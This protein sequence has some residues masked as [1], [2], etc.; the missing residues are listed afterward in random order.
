MKAAI[1]NET[2]DTTLKDTYKVK[3]ATWNESEDIMDAED[4]AV[5]DY[6]RKTHNITP[7]TIPYQSI[8]GKYKMPFNYLWTM[9]VYSQDKDYVFD[10][11]KLVDNSKIEITIHDNYTETTNIVI[12]EYTKYRKIYTTANA[13]VEYYYFDYQAVPPNVP[14][15]PP[16]RSGSL[17]EKVSAATRYEPHYTNTHTTINRNNTLDIALTLADSWFAKYTKEYT[18]NKPT[19]TTSPPSTSSLDDILNEPENV[20]G[21]F[22]GHKDNLI[23]KAESKVRDDAHNIKIYFEDVNTEYTSK[24]LKRSTTTKNIVESSSY[25]S[26]V[27][28]GGGI[29]LGTSIS[30]VKTG[31]LNKDNYIELPSPKTDGDGDNPLQGFC[32]VEDSM[33]AYVIHHYSTGTCSLFLVDSNTTEEYDRTGGF[34]GHGNTIAYDPVNAEII[35]PEDGVIQLVKVNKA[36]KKFEGRRS[37]SPPQRVNSPSQIAYNATHDLFIANSHV[38]TREAFY[39]GGEPIKDLDFEMLEGDDLPA[40]STSYGNHVYYYFADGYGHSTNYLVVCDLNT[41]GQVELIHDNM[42]REGE[43]ASF[44]SDGTLYL[45]HGEAGSPFHKTDYNYFYDT[46]IDTSNVTPGVSRAAN[47]IARYNTGGEYTETGSFEKV[48]NSHYNAKTNILSVKEWLFEALEQNADTVYMI[49]ITKYLISRAGGA[50]EDRETFLAAIEKLQEGFTDIAETGGKSGIPGIQGQIYDYFLAKGVPPVGVAAIMGNIEGESSFKPDNVNSSGH[51]G[52]CQWGGGRFTNL[53]KLA[54]SR[55]KDWT[56][57]ECQLDYLWEELN[58][59]Y[60]SDVKDT[61]MAAVQENKLQYATWY[62]GSYFEVYDLSKNQGFE[63]TKDR[64]EAQKRYKCAQHWYQEW[65]QHHTSGTGGIGVINPGGIT[66]QAEADKLTEQYN[67][68]LNTKVH[69]GDSSYQSGPFPQWWSRPYNQLSPFQCT[70]WANGRASMYLEKYGTKYEKYPTQEGH[71]G[72]YYS[73][74][75]EYGYFNYGSTPKPNSLVSMPSGSSFGHVAYVEGVTSE[76][77]WISDAGSGTSWRGVRFR[78]FSDLNVYGYIYLDE[79][80]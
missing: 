35:F 9:L 38:Y 33:M 17:T 1:T 14:A 71:G 60:Y 31:S 39:S 53:K 58:S 79:P 6:H 21:D 22:G 34:T 40:G 30:N 15:L 70:W 52:L 57:V 78:K 74:N 73:K 26:S 50:E 4:P 11:A 68:M 45:F 23:R 47:D 43:E 25:I 37:I 5:S 59:K 54:A 19:K 64:Q 80:K 20:E 65:Q 66:T 24:I 27:P 75:I 77:I 61:I 7:T 3:V 32:I 67:Q 48:F 44:S 2:T 16:E 42:A 10:L 36:T 46:N 41:G 13:N 72:Q 55:G 76:G 49:D 8:V 18:Y 29:S 63:A 62:W 51:Y 69:D 12:D 56:D 28:G